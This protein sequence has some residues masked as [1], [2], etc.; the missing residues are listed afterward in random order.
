MQ[1]NLGID[2]TGGIHHPGDQFKAVDHRFDGAETHQQTFTIGLPLPPWFPHRAAVVR[3]VL[4]RNN[5]FA[6]VFK[7]AHARRCYV[8]PGHIARCG[9]DAVAM[10]RVR[11][12]TRYAFDMPGRM[13]EADGLHHDR[14]IVFGRNQRPDD[15]ERR[16]DNEIG[17]PVSGELH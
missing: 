3:D 5:G 13:A 17:P 2:F 16:V 12:R 6:V 9:P 15:S 11:K 14:D 7:N 10:I 1:D 4:H 8:D